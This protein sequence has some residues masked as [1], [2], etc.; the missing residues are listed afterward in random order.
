MNSTNVDAPSDSA[1]DALD[2]L[3]H[4]A[5]PAIKRG[6]RRAGVLLDQSRELIDATSQGAGEAI[7]NLGSSLIAYTKKNPLVALLL[8]AGAGAL[9]VTAAKSAQSRRR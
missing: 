6:K 3:Q 9:L 8:A 5:A 7:T 4:A 1:S 2:Q